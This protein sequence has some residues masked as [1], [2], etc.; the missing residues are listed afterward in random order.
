MRKPT[1]VLLAFAAGLIALLCPR[2]MAA[3]AATLPLT[4]RVGTYNVGHFNQ[5]KLGGYQGADPQAAMQRWRQWIK[6]QS[7]DVFF[8]QEWN[9]HFDKDGAMDAT[10]Q[11]LRPLFDN[12]LFGKENR[13]IYN[14]I[15][16]NF[17]LSNLREVPLTHKEYYITQADWQVG[18]V[19]ITIMSVHVPWQERYHESSIDALIAELKRHKYFIC[20][21][22]L[23]APDRNVLKI[24][25]AGIQVANGGDEGWFC[26]AA[27]RCATTKTNV[28]IDNILTSPNIT[29]RKVSAPNTG[30]GD[31]DHLPLLAEVVIQR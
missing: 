30:L 28:N 1:A 11:L 12:V 19:T 21:G 29:I 9:R 6:E 31:Q 7:F 23:N 5:G 17:K 25:A 18:S 14:G 2:G 20:A 15:A 24:R 3:E 13:Y 8:I 22:D 26:T 10:K 27:A 16:T 4:L